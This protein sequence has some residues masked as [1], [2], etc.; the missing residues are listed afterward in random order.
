MI[1]IKFFL[2]LGVKTNKPIKGLCHSKK[3]HNHVVCSAN[4]RPVLDNMF[5]NVTLRQTK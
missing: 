2:I 1:V 5:A 3:S 4:R